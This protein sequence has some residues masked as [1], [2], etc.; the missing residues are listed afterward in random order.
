MYLLDIQKEFKYELIKILNEK[1]TDFNEI[2]P[3]FIKILD[4]N[5]LNKNIPNLKFKILIIN[6][7]YELNSKKLNN[8]NQILFFNIFF[9]F[10]E[11]EDFSFLLL[12]FNEEIGMILSYFLN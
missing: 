5:I 6:N 4:L 8:E 2:I 10:I 1:K 7:L 11:N 12:N 3:N 9:D